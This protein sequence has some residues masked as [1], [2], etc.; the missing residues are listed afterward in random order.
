MKETSKSPKVIDNKR[1]EAF[2]LGLVVALSILF[3]AFEYTSLPKHSDSNDQ[4]L[5]QISQELELQTPDNR[6]MM[7][8]QEAAPANAATQNLI[9]QDKPSNEPLKISS[10]TNPLVIGEGQG[11]NGQA[12]VSEEVQTTTAQIQQADTAVYQLRTVEQLPLFPGGWAAL[13]TWL[14]HNLH[15][16]AIARDQKIQGKVVVSFII[17]K[18][19]TVSNIKVEQSVD[20]SLDR[21][22]LRVVKL[23]PKW[24]PA[25]LHGKPCRSMFVIPI[26]FSL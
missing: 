14:T 15:Y 22:A 9:A 19:G 2:L 1:A 4:L 13:M 8:I 10:V 5:E 21:E 11:L 26:V 18:D 24:K 16:P 3:V 25:I 17:N 12:K 20:V 7:S 23:M 6:D